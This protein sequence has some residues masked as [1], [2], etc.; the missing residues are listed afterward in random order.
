MDWDAVR[1]PAYL[2]DRVLARL[3][4]D[5]GAVIRDPYAHLLYWLIKPGTADDWSFSDEAQ[6]R[7]LGKGSCVV[8]PPVDCDRSAVVYWA[9]PIVNGRILTSSW[10]LYA[11]VRTVI[12]AGVAQ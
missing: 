3:G 12:R 2:G 9:R 5:C 11:A 4:D 8:V 10:P 7:I 6:V 1:L